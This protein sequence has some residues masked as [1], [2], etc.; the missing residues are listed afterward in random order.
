MRGSIF[1]VMALIASFALPVSAQF[2]DRGLV[3]RCGVT[4]L[5]VHNHANTAHEPHMM[6]YT[7]SYQMPQADG[8]TKTFEFIQVDAID[9]QGR[10]M[11]SKT[12][13][14][15]PE[16]ESQR[17]LVCVYDPVA[18][19]KTTWSVPGKQA[20]QMKI[21][22]IESS[23]SSCAK[24]KTPE[25]NVLR[26][27]PVV[28]DF[29]T[30]TIHGYEARGFKIT[31]S[32]STHANGKDKTVVRSVE[33]WRAPLQGLNGLVGLELTD[34][35]DNPWQW[36][37][38]EKLGYFGPRPPELFDAVRGRASLVVRE[39]VDDS[40]LG[41]GSEELQD[42]RQGNPD[43]AVFQ[44]PEGYTIVTKKATPAACPK[45]EAPASTEPPSSPAQ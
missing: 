16:E 21:A 44:P 11:N 36:S 18:G 43:P 12:A 35:F 7:V 24:D 28:E 34:H 4:S 1:G 13:V 26:S 32:I 27:E 42:F 37:K 23:R 3:E 15:S 25:V 38:S 5:P 8:T 6:K 17:T 39:V 31:R 45:E 40:R 22:E 2:E 10:W 9:S 30:E 29:G 14:P 41:K 19:I 33:I 20:T